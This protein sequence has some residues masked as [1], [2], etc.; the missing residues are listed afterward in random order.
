[1]SKPVTGY[2]R[3]AK[4]CKH[5]SLRYSV[6]GKD[7]YRVLKEHGNYIYDLARAKQVAEIITEP[8]RLKD[9]IARESVL[10]A[11]IQQKK[12]RYEESVS[13]VKKIEKPKIKIDDIWK[14]YVSI[15]VPYRKNTGEATLRQY[16][17]QIAKFCKY[18]Q[19]NFQVK[20]FEDI[21]TEMLREWALSL[22]GEKVSEN[23]Q[24]KHWRL[25]NMIFKSICKRKEYQNPFI[26]VEFMAV[27]NL[28]TGSI[29]AEKSSNGR[30]R[31]TWEQVEYIIN[32][33]DGELKTLLMLMAYTSQR[34]KDCCL[35]TWEQVNLTKQ[36]IIFS[37]FKTRRTKS[38]SNIVR[39]PMHQCLYEA[40]ASCKPDGEYVLPVLAGRYKR[41]SSTISNII[42]S[43]LR[44]CGIQPTE[45]VDK[46]IIVVYGS[47][48][49]RKT[50]ISLMA[51]AGIAEPIR[52]YIANH[53]HPGVHGR[54]IQISHEKVREAIEAL[55]NIASSP[56][57]K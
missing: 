18:I 6:D 36:E 54:Y 24:L 33:A 27:D 1:M 53:S 49:F 9:E 56:T 25:V 38:R 46:R 32:S 47:H 5:Y 7:Y 21:T 11:R 44:E 41:R 20:H 40:L 50:A 55:P 35:L 42:S 4:N 10:L 39:I 23:T 34:L 30:K 17:F 52:M 14:Y 26:G 12:Q 57:Q 22:Q 31:F 48:S 8:F 15:P 29:F 19:N 13:A 28:A 37:P 43:H 16:G 51:E 2:V 45:T 3:K